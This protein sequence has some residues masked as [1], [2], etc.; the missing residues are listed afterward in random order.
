MDIWCGLVIGLVSRL[1]INLI[2]FFLFAG[3]MSGYEVVGCV[4]D[5]QDQTVSIARAREDARNAK[6]KFEMVRRLSERGSASLKSLRDAK[7]EMNLSIIQ[8]SNLMDPARTP[9]NL[10]LRA[11]LILQY[12]NEELE[13]AKRL[14]ENGSV[15]KVTFDRMIAVRNIAASR[16]K[17]IESD[18]EA[19]RKIQNIKASKLRLEIV[20]KEYEVANRLF[21]NGSVS[22][23][24]LDLAKSKLEVAKAELAKSKKALGAKASKVTQ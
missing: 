21:R 19:Q 13:V 16:L 17:A 8:L 4:Q 6:K 15:A 20:F 1:G 12:R 9:R 23:F 3:G 18:T 10:V 2:A 7:L 11:K 5:M 22:Q 24:D 14:F